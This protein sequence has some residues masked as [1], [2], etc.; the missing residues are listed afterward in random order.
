MAVS[1][2]VIKAIVT[3]ATDKRTWKALAILLAAI[4]MPLILLIL[5]IAAMFSGVESANN[6][7]LDYSFVGTAMPNNFTDEQ[8]RTIEDMRDRLGELDEF[9]SEKKNNEE[10]SL[11]GNMVRAAFYCL[12]FGAE[13][14]EDF[15]YRAFCDCF[16]GLSFEQLDTA[17][18]TV[19]EEFPQYVIT[20]NIE[21]SIPQ[22]YKYLNGKEIT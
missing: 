2:V 11:D 4:F 20:E 3:A 7:L 5:M 13:L 9:I 16:D 12:N 8:R 6:D 17:L 21:Y 1:P 10:R 19:S 18:Q 14:D 22:V 15:D